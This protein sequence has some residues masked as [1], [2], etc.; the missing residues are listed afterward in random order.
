MTM[1]EGDTFTSKTEIHDSETINIEMVVVEVH[2]Y[3]DGSTE[4]E[5]EITEESEEE[6]KE[7]LEEYGYPD[8]TN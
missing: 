5:Y 1:N 6:V 4:E 2:E 7:L 3:E 8:G